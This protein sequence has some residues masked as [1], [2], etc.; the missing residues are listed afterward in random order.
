MEHISQRA[1]D[2][3]VQY[4]SVSGCYKLK[5]GDKITIMVTGTNAWTIN[6]RAKGN[7]NISLM[8]PTN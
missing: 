6:S 1:I 3:G 4:I 5:A 2:N 8:S 7:V